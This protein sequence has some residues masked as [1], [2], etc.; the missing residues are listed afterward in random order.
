MLCISTNVERCKLMTMILS[1]LKSIID[2]IDSSIADYIDW[3][4]RLIKAFISITFHW[5]V[6]KH[7]INFSMRFYDS[8]IFDVESVSLE[9]VLRSCGTLLRYNIW[10]VFQ[11]NDNKDII[12]MQL[13]SRSKFSHLLQSHPM[14]SYAINVSII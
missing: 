11:L 10:E 5:L 1:Q 13:R 9:I 7:P 3:N 4:V 2:E 6:S 12:N 14:Y 8:S